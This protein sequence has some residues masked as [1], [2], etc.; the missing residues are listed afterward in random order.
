MIPIR[1]VKGK[2]NIVEGRDPNS[3]GRR[4]R[5]KTGGSSI[6]PLKKLKI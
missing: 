1:L 5:K 6:S 2:G 3:R 4:G